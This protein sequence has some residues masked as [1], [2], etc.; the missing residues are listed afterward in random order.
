MIPDPPTPAPSP[1]G[2][3]ESLE[4]AA[5]ARLSGII[6]I[7]S[8]AIVSV[9]REQRI[10]LFN[11]GAETIFGYSA[12][13]VLG[14]PLDLLLPEGVHAAH[15][16]H[17]RAFD[18][19]PD[20]ARRMG[21]RHE[22]AGRRKGGEEFPA[23]ASILKADV[24][25]E[26]LFTVMLRDVTERRRREVGQ[27]FLSEAGRVLA[28]SLDLR[29]T[30]TSVVELVVDHLGDLCIVDLVE[31]GGRVRRIESAQG[32][33][34]RPGLADGLATVR[35]DRARPHLMSRALHEGESELVPLT[36]AGHLDAIAQNPDHR[37][38]LEGLRGG[39]YLTVPLRAR[40]STLGALLCARVGGGRPLDDRD[41]ELAEEIGRRAGMAVDNARLYEEA[42]DAVRARDHVV[43]VVSHDLGN[44]LQAIFIALDA[45]ERE[46]APAKGAPYYLTAIHRSAE[47]MQ[48]LV[49]DLLAFRRM[50]GGHQTLERS[51]A[52]LTRLVDE[53]LGEMEPLALAKEVEL[54][55][56]LLE[57]R[58]PRVSVDQARIQQVLLNL[59][60]NA[61]KHAPVGGR[62]TVRAGTEGAE[63]W[64]SVEDDG[65]G[66]A[67]EHLEHVFEP[68]WRLDGTRG[69]GAGLGL[70]ISRGIVEAH[71]GRIW[72]RAGS[73]GG[74]TLVFTLPAEEPAGSPEGSRAGE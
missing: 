71:G 7:A 48:S 33:R 9:D 37:R 63:V 53:A 61:V 66:I 57:E 72:A 1:A 18:A 41:L 21:E 26:R 73:E 58:I 69:G 50:D 22:I 29:E 59:L 19:G 45:L 65:P 27:A 10:R 28:S 11:H 17:I 55:N 67:E 5:P 23:E 70:A 12:E 47:R 49:Q 43:S 8:D 51:P 44:P 40:G 52:V 36:S 74:A 31:P 46:R 56:R 2:E 60:G 15:Q 54:R 6:A 3:H 68:F 32:A 24:G 25:G 35:I 64:L 42:R 4:L 39:S 38:R 30:L 16:G 13:E 14:E 20:V 62:V 34:A